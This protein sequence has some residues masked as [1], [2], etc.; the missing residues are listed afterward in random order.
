[1]INIYGE[2]QESEIAEEGALVQLRAMIRY[3]KDP[4][5]QTIYE[6]KA[7]VFPPTLTS[8]DRQIF[9]IQNLVKKTDEKTQTK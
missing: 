1:M 3:T 5:M 4:K 2:L 8:E 6:C 7:M 9:D